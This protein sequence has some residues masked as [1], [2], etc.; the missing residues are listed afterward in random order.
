M[1]SAKKHLLRA[2]AAATEKSVE[3][4]L[5]TTSGYPNAEAMR[6]ALLKSLFSHPA[7][8]LATV[9]VHK[10]S[11]SISVNPKMKPRVTDIRKLDGH[12]QA[13]RLKPRKHG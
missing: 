3:E 13:P 1:K 5:A 7:V 9:Q 4:A 8:K 10:M 12:V 11:Q 6:A 2:L